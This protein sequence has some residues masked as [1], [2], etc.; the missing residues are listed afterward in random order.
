MGPKAS[1]RLPACLQ[2]GPD[3]GFTTKGGW[4]FLFL[5]PLEPTWSQLTCG[6]H[7]KAARR[8]LLHVLQALGGGF[9]QLSVWLGGGRK[10]T[11]ERLPG[12]PPVLMSAATENSVVGGGRA[13]PRTGEPAASCVLHISHHQG[14]STAPRSAVESHSWYPEGG[15]TQTRNK[16]V[17]TPRR[18]MIN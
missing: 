17:L 9:S 16:A 18:R 4:T 3:P 8:P 1:W 13:S 2:P 7:Q 5:A 10:R 11:L 14:W 12:R 6:A 15:S